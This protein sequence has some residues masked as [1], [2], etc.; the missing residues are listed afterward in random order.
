MDTITMSY[1]L[2]LES[3][4]TC[5]D[6]V[7]RATNLKGDRRCN[8]IDTISQPTNELTMEQREVSIKLETTLK[9]PA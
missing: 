9:L 8:A 7:N 6:G 3:Y 5:M 4:Q 1:H 2:Y